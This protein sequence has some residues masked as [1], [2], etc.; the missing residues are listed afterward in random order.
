MGKLTIKEQ[1]MRHVETHGNDMCRV[2][3]LRFVYELTR[4]GK[5][6]DPV[7][8]RGFY[9]CAF[10]KRYGG[11]FIQGGKA[12]LR[13][14]KSGSYSVW[15]KTVDGSYVKTDQFNIM[16]RCSNVHTSLKDVQKIGRELRIDPVNVSKSVAP[17]A[18]IEN[19]V[20]NSL[21]SK[22][23]EVSRTFISASEYT[24]CHKINPEN[25]ELFVDT[26]NE[27]IRA[28]ELTLNTGLDQ[29]PIL[30]DKEFIKVFRDASDEG[31]ILTWTA[32]DHNTV[33]YRMIPKN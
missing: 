24:R 32:D 33:T 13:K 28:G 3:I 23:K 30:N 27:A 21:L 15:R 9:S 19:I 31:W 5:K 17:I 26:F 14:N 1:A 20:I 4:L 2:D 8:H 6:Y 16:T 25:I 29:I 7:K 22:S 12:E 18:N 11:H 10:C